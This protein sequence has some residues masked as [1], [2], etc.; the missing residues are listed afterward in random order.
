MDK[1]TQQNTA[2]AEETASATEEMS[3]Q[4]MHMK[5][6]IGILSAQVGEQKYIIYM[7]C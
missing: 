7:I 1:V 5:D 6:Q 3:A 4:A 2:N